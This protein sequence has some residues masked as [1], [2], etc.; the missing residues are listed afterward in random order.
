M[1]PVLLVSGATEKKPQRKRPPA[2]EPGTKG[3][4]QY[5][6]NQK[7]YDHVVTNFPRMKTA[8]DDQH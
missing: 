2:N 6:A 7:E 5:K 3:G 1:T 8:R 4:A